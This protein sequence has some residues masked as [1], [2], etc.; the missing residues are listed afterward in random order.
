MSKREEVLDELAMVKTLVG[1][2]L[3]GIDFSGQN[4]TN[5][6]FLPDW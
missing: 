3:S 4:F 5:C 1:E 6:A 2:D